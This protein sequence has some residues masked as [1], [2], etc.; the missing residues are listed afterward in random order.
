MNSASFFRMDALRENERRLL[1]E[2]HL[3][4]PAAS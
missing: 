3:V 2:R 1:V 4:S